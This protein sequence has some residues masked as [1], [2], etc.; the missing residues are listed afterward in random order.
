MRVLNVRAAGMVIL[1]TA[2]SMGISALAEDPVIDS[3]DHTG[4][5]TCTNLQ[6]H[7]MSTVEWAPSMTGPWTNTWESL[8]SVMADSNG[9][10]SVYV[11]VFYRVRGVPYQPV[12]TTT[13]AP[14]TT[15][16]TAA[17]TT[18][19]ATGTTTSTTVTSTS[20]STTTVTPTTT[21]TTTAIVQS[22]M[23]LIPGGTNA[24]TDPD[25]GAY[26]L[27]VTSF[28][29]DR[30]EVTKALWD[31]VKNW[32]GGNGYSYDNTGGVGVKTSN[33]PVHSVNWYDCFKWCNARSQKDGRT[34]VYYTDA[35][36][37]QIYKT[38]QVSRPYVKASANGYRLPTDVQWEYAARGGVANRRFPWNDSAEIQHARANYSSSSLYSYD[39]S[40]TRGFHPTYN[41]GFHPY[42][43]PVGAFVPNG[44]GLYDM[45]G[46][47]WEWCYDWYP[48]LEGS[49]P[50]LRGGGWYGV[51]YFCRV[52]NRSHT[53]P[54]SASDDI[55]FRAVLP[56]G[57][58]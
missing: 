44:Y 37:T 22:V 46:N 25:F 9:V 55:G 53:D 43:S 47:V 8:R 29:M 28:Y 7:S 45:A 33:H 27:T 13:V 16:T 57:Q 30:Y 58:Q 10:I 40:A 38:G 2:I 14:T 15:T 48:G 24:G 18:T 51:A 50:V 19:T 11:P 1:A 20:T 4:H 54:D 23:V 52:G 35:G 41:D 21:T 5:L 6:P 17:P 56:S 31:E 32:N 34:P 3:F 39:T 26:S 36:F 12:T 42:S 49:R